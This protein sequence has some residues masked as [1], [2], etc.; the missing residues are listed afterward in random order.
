MLERAKILIVEDNV[1]NRLLL[2]K[3]IT[4]KYEIL[5]ATNGQE[6]LDFL[7]VKNHGIAAVLLDLV[8]P[9]M[10]GYTFLQVVRAKRELAKLPIIVLAASEDNKTEV[11]VLKMGATE[12]LRKPYEPTLVRQRLANILLLSDAVKFRKLAEHDTLTGIYNKDTFVA[13]TREMLL[14]NMQQDYDLICLNIERFK[15]VNDLFG[16]AEGD[17]LLC[18]LANYIDKKW[19]QKAATYGRIGGD[20]FAVC[21]PRTAG[22]E[23]KMLEAAEQNLRAYPLDLRV[24]VAYGIYRIEDHTL[25]V[26]TMCDRALLAANS[27]KG[28]YDKNYAVYTEEHRAALLREQAVINDM[29]KALEQREFVVYYQ[30]KFDLDQGGIVGAEGLVRWQHPTKGLIAP[31][32]FIPIFE[33]NGFITV[34]DEYVWEEVCKLLARLQKT[35]KQVLP[36]SVNVSRVDIYNPSL[37]DKL[38]A[39]IK[40]YKLPPALL[41]LEITETSYTDNQKQLI[42]VVHRLKSLGF[43]VQMDDFGKGYSSLNMLNDVPVDAIKLDM[44]FLHDTKVGVRSGN[45]LNFVV[46]MANWLGMPVIAEGVETLE[47]VVFLRSIG[48]NVGQGYYFSKPIPE[49]EFLKILHSLQTTPIRYRIKADSESIDIAEF[50][51]PDSA[52]NLLFNNFVGALVLLEAIGERVSV[53]RAN[54][55]YYKLFGVPRACVYRVAA[56]LLEQVYPQDKEKFLS[57][58]EEASTSGNEVT[59][60]CRW[61]NPKTAQLI[62]LHQGVRM[63]YQAGKRTIFLVSVEDFTRIKTDENILRVGYVEAANYK[64]SQIAAALF[65]FKVDL[66][67]GKVLETTFELAKELLLAGQNEMETIYK[68]FVDL[69][70]HPEERQMV[71]RFYDRKTILSHFYQGEKNNYIE[72]RCKTDVAAKA[73]RWVSVTYNYIKDTVTDHVLAFVYLRDI[74]EK[75]IE[76]LEIQ[77]KAQRDQL[78]GLYN[79]GTFVEMTANFLQKRKDTQKSAFIFLDLDDFKLVNDTYGHLQ[80]DKLLTQVGNLLQETFHGDEIIGR[81]GGDEM[82]IFV[83]KIK[84]RE[85]ALQKGWSLCHKL[86]NK[87]SM[88]EGM[89]IGCSVGIAL[90]PEHGTSFDV[91]Y[92]HADLALY[93]A[94]QYGKNQCALY[95]EQLPPAVIPH[96]MLNREWL[97]D[98]VDDLIYVCDVETYNLIYVNQA[99]L[100]AYH[101]EHKSYHNK[102]CYEFMF[103]QKQPCADC[104]KNELSYDKFH[105]WHCRNF[106]L[107]RDYIIK[108]KLIKWNDRTMRLEIAV[109]ISGEDFRR[110]EPV[111]K[112]K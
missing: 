86:Q 11:D 49:N 92:H 67:A 36:I 93:K 20:I 32:D 28:S 101:N 82:A 34:L 42:D 66:S 30:P 24:V 16:E 33:K 51:K 112:S 94:K 44:K 73:Y 96:E 110:D 81:F 68:H 18:Y 106:Q 2:R 100:V 79:R 103:G 78:S 8:M 9:V 74:H 87:I 65:Y 23:P 102:K 107:Q 48:C 99:A 63:I 55:R 58:L 70:V 109:D 10:D 62:W 76:E 29:H 25:P 61:Y 108:N 89:T 91:L 88:P 90:A 22:Y 21:V 57:L 4:N 46:N 50:W 84:S 75:K 19:Y 40:K 59:G 80:G 47:Q 35:D 41:E 27:V 104:N 52:V 85:E 98:E 3:I 15:L 17:A 7:M 77:Y 14:A 1:T 13:R 6:A 71:K 5:E 105:N 39:L 38:V 111:H 60:D 54:D 53:L 43:I 31:D 37:C 64:H 45:I 69:M 97:M 95:D 56:N 12:F 26:T 72:C 83:P